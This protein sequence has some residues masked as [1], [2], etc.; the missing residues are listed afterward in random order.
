MH[1][2]AGSQKKLTRCF[3]ELNVASQKY[4]KVAKLEKWFMHTGGYTVVPWLERAHMKKR[5]STNV[6]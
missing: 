6:R 4:Q 1:K 3:R 2:A 5:I